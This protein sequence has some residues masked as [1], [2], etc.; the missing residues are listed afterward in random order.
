MT[1]LLLRFAAEV[2]ASSWDLVSR[3]HTTSIKADGR[4]R[5]PSLVAPTPALLA[6]ALPYKETTYVGQDGAWFIEET[7]AR[8]IIAGRHSM[9]QRL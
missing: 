8:G 4:V 2:M 7:T 3:H 1:E 5:A 6:A 9:E